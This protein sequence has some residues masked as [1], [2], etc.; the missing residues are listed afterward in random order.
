MKIPLLEGRDFT[1]RDTAGAPPVVIVNERVAKTFWPKGNATGKRLTFDDPRRNPRWLTIVGVS[2]NVKQSGWADS[3][4]D[5]C[6]V[7][8]LQEKDFLE[9][10]HSWVSYMTLVS[11]RRAI[12]CIRPSSSRTPSGQSTRT[13]RCPRSR[14]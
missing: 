11:G 13:Y 12:R 6:Y 9:G 1:N 10:A 4:D 2:K 5:E 8:F 14:R 7:P 3:P